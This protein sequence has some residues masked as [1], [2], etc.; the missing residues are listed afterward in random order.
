MPSTSFDTIVIGKGIAG[1]A[2]AL[3]LHRR[4]NKVAI[5]S[6]GPGATSVSSGAWDFCRIPAGSP[7]SFEQLSHTQ[8]W[9]TTFAKILTSQPNM[10][11]VEDVENSLR[12]ITAAFNPDLKLSFSLARPYFLPTTA[13]TWKRTFGAQSIQALADLSALHRRRVGILNCGA[14][15]FRGDLIAPLLSSFI[16]QMEEKPEIVPLT[17][18]L[19]SQAS[20]WAIPNFAVQLSVNSNVRN[21][22]LTSLS[23]ALKKQKV[24]VILCPPMFLDTT[25]ATQIQKELGVIIAEF[26]GT[27][28]PTAGMRMNAAIDSAITRLSLP[29][30]TA[31]Q[32]EPET[33]G[34]NVARLRVLTRTGWSVFEAKHLI[35]ASGKLFGGGVHLG[36]PGIK[37][38]VFGLPLFSHHSSDPKH[39]RTQLAWGERTFFEDQEWAALGVKVNSNWKVVDHTGNAVY[40]N[41]YACGS[42]LGGLDFSRHSVGTGFMAYT[43]R[44]CAFA[45]SQT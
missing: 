18:Q 44:Q 42:I 32:I 36:Y 1:F 13:G 26:L 29:S 6:R 2:S 12:E 16:Q 5:L 45:V 20:D 41:V 28:E 21:Q 24:D 9:K 8:D 25:M 19:D 37:E 17:L 7:Q 38:T 3:S 33:E 34:G 40:E 4:N 35:L 31:L 10:P 39:L 22:F 23:E 30:F 27:T 15:R 11:S 14:L 43:G